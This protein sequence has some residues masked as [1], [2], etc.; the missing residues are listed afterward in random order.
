MLVAKKLYSFQR[1]STWIAPTPGLTAPKPDDPKLDKNLHYLEE[2]RKRFEDPEYLLAHRK[3]IYHQGCQNFRANLLG[4]PTQ[5]DAIKIFT[6]TMKQRLNHD[7]EIIDHIIPD[8]PVG[9]RRNTPGP[10]FLEALIK[11]N[12]TVITTPIEMITAKGLR[13]ADGREIT[14]D[15]VVC[16]TGFDATFRPRFPLIG[17]EERSLSEEWTASPPDAYL[18]IAVSGYPNYFSN[19]PSTM[20]RLHL[21]FM[22]PNTPVANG[23]LLGSVQ[24]Q[25]DYMSKVQT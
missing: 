11:D 3:A 6:E 20:T 24:A 18:G 4:T 7:Q 21:A 22:G 25:G 13:L 17:R 1:S 12:V 23:T 16:A 5:I 8:F 15:V 10:G 2:E 14:C 19:R 9:C